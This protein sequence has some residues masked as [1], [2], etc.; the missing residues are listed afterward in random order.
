MKKCMYPAIFTYDTENNS[1]I[2]DFIDLMGCTTEGKTIDEAYEMAQDAMG[3]YLC[4]LTDNEL[5][6]P[7]LPPYNN[8]ELKE[9]EFITLVY[10]DLN[11]YR[12]KYNNTAVKKTLTIP[13]W[14]NTLAEKNN[15]NFS[16]VLQEALKAKLNIN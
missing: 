13:M 3:L 1:Y 5:P 12:K 10:L 11:E 15:T 16:Q 4:D 14:L 6:K 9:N 7:S 8:T 2:V